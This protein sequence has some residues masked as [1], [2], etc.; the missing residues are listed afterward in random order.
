MVEFDGTV[1]HT[2]IGSTFAAES[3]TLATALDRQLYVRLLSETIL[4]GELQ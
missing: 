1:I 3:A 4:F 2:V